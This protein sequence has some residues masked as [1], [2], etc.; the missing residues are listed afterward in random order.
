MSL[1]SG[2]LSFLGSEDELFYHTGCIVV[3]FSR[4]KRKFRI[5][6]AYSLGDH[7]DRSTDYPSGG[8]LCSCFR[9]VDP[10]RTNGIGANLYCSLYLSRW[11]RRRLSESRTC[12]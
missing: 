12:P 6:S 10:L 3:P 5:Q 1:R 4:S 8:S 7:N 2:K 9:C 11:N